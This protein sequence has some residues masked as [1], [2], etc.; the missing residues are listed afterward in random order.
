MYM[1]RSSGISEGRFLYAQSSEIF[2]VAL[3][4]DGFLVDLE[5][6]LCHFVLIGL[7]FHCILYLEHL[8]FLMFYLWQQHP[9]FG[10][11]PLRVSDTLLNVISPLLLEIKEI[12][13]FLGKKKKHHLRKNL[14]SLKN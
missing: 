13:T 11:S 14:T 2:L 7:G 8:L 10:F 6:L 12:M 4:V 3:E 1:S 9:L 5:V